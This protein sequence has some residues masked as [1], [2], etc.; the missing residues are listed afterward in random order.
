MRESVIAAFTAAIHCI[1]EDIRNEYVKRNTHGLHIHCPSPTPK[2]GPS[3][4]AAFSCAIISRILNKPIK[5]DIAM[6]GEVELTG[7]VAKIG[8]LIYKLTGA[9]RAGVKTVF[10][11][12][13]NKDDIEQIIRDTDGLIDKNFEIILINNIRDILKHILIGYDASQFN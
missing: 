9:K 13:E 12:E 2:N 7:K 8:G 3:G 11:P 5:N 1:R 4:G 6:T 10:V